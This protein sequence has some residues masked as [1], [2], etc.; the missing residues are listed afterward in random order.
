PPIDS[1]T[2]TF[3][4]TDSLVH[5]VV[6]PIIIDTSFINTGGLWQI[7]NTT[8][9]IFSTNGIISRGIMTDTTG[10]YPSNSNNYFTLKLT[11]NFNS[12]SSIPNPIIEV[13]HEY[14]T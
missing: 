13:W 8:K 6:D 2:I 11:S 10:F 7:G 5:N 14:Q 1:T 3:N 9:P 12:Y 4:T